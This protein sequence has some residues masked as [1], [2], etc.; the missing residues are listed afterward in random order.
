MYGHSGES[1]KGVIPPDVNRFQKIDLQG[2]QITSDTLFLPLRVIEERFRLI[3][4]WEIAGGQF[5]LTAV[6]RVCSIISDRIY[7]SPDQVS[8]RT[9]YE[10]GELPVSI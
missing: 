8:E 5:F 6:G 1:Q 7:S 3:A 4:P 10:L 2:T 9:R